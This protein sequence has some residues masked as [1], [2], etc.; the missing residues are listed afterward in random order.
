MNH[1]NVQIIESSRT[2]FSHRVKG[3]ATPLTQLSLQMKPPYKGLFIKIKS[4]N[5][6]MARGGH[7]QHSINTANFMTMIQITIAPRLCDFK[8]FVIAKKLI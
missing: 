2:V 5:C 1:I 4:K 3:K 8:I 7:K 6:V